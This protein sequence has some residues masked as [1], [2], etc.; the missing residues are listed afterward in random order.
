MD[1]AS[2]RINDSDILAYYN[3][4]KDC[5]RVLEA[6]FVHPP[7]TVQEKRLPIAFGIIVHKGARLFE[8]ILRAIYMSNNVY[9]IHIDKK[10][11]DVFRRAIQA[12]I[13]CL[14]NVFI[15]A[16]SID[17]VWGHVSLVQAQFSCMEK[18]LQSEVKW[19]YYISLVGQ[20][21]PLYDN[22]QI[23]RALQS[24]KKF[25]NIGSY[26]MVTKFA[27]RIEYV[28][29]LKN[30]TAKKTR[31]LKSSPPRNITIFKGST[32]IIAIREFVDFV[33]HSKIGKDLF[34]YLK[35]TYIPDE[36]IY[37]SLQQLPLAP[38]G[39]KG[40]QP[41]SIARALQWANRTH[42]ECHGTW[43]RSVC[44][45]SIED[46]SWALGNKWKK[47]LFLHKIPFDFNDELL[48]CILVA[49]QGRK[50][51]TTVWKPDRTDHTTDLKTIQKLKLIKAERKEA[52]QP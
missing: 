52:D 16:N 45:I 17:V 33:L 5:R 6:R 41:S 40:K 4:N 9:C 32:F 27:D 2:S 44:W 11:P 49:R 46:L 35:D 7:L 19:K 24:L 31:V 15:S 30:K 20:D 25:N 29:T 14:P 26:P 37:A 12:I 1:E 10:S 21:F 43:V 42:S 47:K 13:R 50:Y 38:G 8:R 18:L 23:V 34:E 51:G 39:I 36:T 28:Y 48:E 3:G 22:K